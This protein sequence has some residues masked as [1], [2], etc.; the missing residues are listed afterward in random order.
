MN[1]YIVKLYKNIDDLDHISVDINEENVNEWTI[2]FK[3][4]NKYKIIFDDFPNSCPKKIIPLEGDWMKYY[5]SRVQKNKYGL[6]MGWVH[7]N[8]YWNDI[9]NNIYDK[10]II[11][12]IKSITYTIND[13]HTNLVGRRI[14]GLKKLCNN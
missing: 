6:C 14:S 2:T 12:L 3:D 7:S 4:T 1:K 11:S 5:T 8:K 13:P 9:W 10:N